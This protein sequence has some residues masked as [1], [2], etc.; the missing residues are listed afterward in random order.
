MFKKMS[1]YRK[2][3]KS[4]KRTNATQFSLCSNLEFY[5]KNTKD[6]RTRRTKKTYIKKK[7]NYKQSQINTT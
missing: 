7:Q 1:L 6:K 3:T 4:I 5:Q 2:K